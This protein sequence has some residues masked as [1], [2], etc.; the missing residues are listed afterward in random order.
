MDHIVENP[1]I[2][3]PDEVHKIIGCAMTVYNTLGRG[4]LEAVY[5]DALEVEL[6]LQGISFEHKKH[7]RI[8]I[9]SFF[10][11]NHYL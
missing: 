10:N 7:L 8:S 4:F 11:E 2:L 3:Y 6:E 5:H 9:N 1:E